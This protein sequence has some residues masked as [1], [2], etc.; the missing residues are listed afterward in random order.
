[1]S[2]LG[3]L[4]PHLKSYDCNKLFVRTL[5]HLH[6]LHG[7]RAALSDEYVPYPLA[8]SQSLI[9]RRLLETNSC[10]QQNGICNGVNVQNYYSY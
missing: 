3:K 4:L 6:H 5:V 7:H 2:S 10:H 9:S 1:M 8:A